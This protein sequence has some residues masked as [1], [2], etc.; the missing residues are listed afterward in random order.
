MRAISEGCKQVNMITSKQVYNVC[1]RYKNFIDNRACVN[2]IDRS[3]S[4]LYTG[5]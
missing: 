4:V 5:L 3:L 1:K 2:R